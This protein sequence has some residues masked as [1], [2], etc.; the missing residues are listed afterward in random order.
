MV[1]YVC[2]R[3]HY[4]TLLHYYNTTSTTFQNYLPYLK[5]RPVCPCA[6]LLF[7]VDRG[8]HLEFPNVFPGPKWP[9]GQMYIQNTLCYLKMKIMKSCNNVGESSS[10]GVQPLSTE[11]HVIC[12]AQV[13]VVDQQY[14]TFQG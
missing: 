8:S 10:H 12:K 5:S 2:I 13:V 6:N 4:K 1:S 7:S 11:N 9:C 3:N 14:E